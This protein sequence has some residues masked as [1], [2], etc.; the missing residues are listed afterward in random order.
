MCDIID[1][2]GDLDRLPVWISGGCSVDVLLAQSSRVLCQGI[3]A[4]HPIPV[5]A[6]RY[7]ICQGFLLLLRD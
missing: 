2:A 3:S 4:F 1:L 6:F 7:S 5:H